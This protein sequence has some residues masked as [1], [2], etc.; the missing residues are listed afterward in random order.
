MALSVDAVFT[1]QY[2]GVVAEIRL[3]PQFPLSPMRS[4]HANDL[5]SAKG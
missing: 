2:G 1:P 3:E 4:C 5:G